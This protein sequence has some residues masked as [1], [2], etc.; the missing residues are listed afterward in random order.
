M[1]NEIETP[2]S[3]GDK[4][5]RRD[6]PSPSDYRSGEGRELPRGSS[7]QPRCKTN[8][9]HSNRPRRPLVAKIFKNVQ[10]KFQWRI[11]L[12]LFKFM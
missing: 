11:L 5:Y 6:I 2:M 8:L 9:V 1:A 10:H 7:A 4:L 3:L 12:Y